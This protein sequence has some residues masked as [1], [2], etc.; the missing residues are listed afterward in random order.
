MPRDS[1][2]ARS[3]QGMRYK[4]CAPTVCRVCTKVLVLSNC[5]HPWGRFCDYLI[6]QIETLRLLEAI[7]SPKALSW[8]GARLGLRPVL[9]N[10]KTGVSNH[11]AVGHCERVCFCYTLGSWGGGAM[12]FQLRLSRAG[13]QCSARSRR[14]V[15]ACGLGDWD[16]ERC[17][18]FIGNGKAPGAGDGGEGVRRLGDSRPPGREWAQRRLGRP[19]LPVHVSRTAALGGGC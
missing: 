12:P 2:F 16:S 8:E 14:S 4:G 7:E 9:C 10:F 15:S 3:R 5:S 18:G 13:W 19:R 1:A 17:V 6:L 11:G